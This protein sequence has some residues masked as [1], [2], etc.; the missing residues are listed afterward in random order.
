[1]RQS[2]GLFVHND[3]NSVCELIDSSLTAFMDELL[4]F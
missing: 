1:L 2:S 3:P 4:I